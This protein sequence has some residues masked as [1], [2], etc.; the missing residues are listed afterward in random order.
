MI[1]LG[2]IT[3]NASVLSGSAVAQLT[4][5]D[6]AQSLTLCTRMNVDL[7]IHISMMLR[8]A[9]ISLLIMTI[10]GPQGAT[11]IGTIREGGT[12]S[13]GGITMQPF[14]STRVRLPLLAGMFAMTA[15]AMLQTTMIV[16]RTW[17]LV[18]LQ[19]FHPPHHLYR[20]C[21]SISFEPT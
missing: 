14:L 6:T 11:A 3:I 8:G 7:Y 2:W 12:R 9:S 21:R 16:F 4:L 13:R 20:K 19:T 18:S 15:H 17:T 10:L 5:I 1:I